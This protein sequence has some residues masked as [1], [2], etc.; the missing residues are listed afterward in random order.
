[1]EVGGAWCS[2]LP[3]SNCRAA[4]AHPGNRQEAVVVSIKANDMSVCS[5]G[6]SSLWPQD[7]RC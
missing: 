2:P 3:G 6:L 4:R 5:K 7:F 1:M